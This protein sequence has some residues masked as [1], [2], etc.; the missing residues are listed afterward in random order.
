MKRVEITLR[1]GA[2]LAAIV[3][4][5]S[6]AQAQSTLPPPDVAQAQ[7]SPSTEATSADEIVVTGS[8]IAR[9]ALRDIPR[10]LGA[11]DFRLDDEALSFIAQTAG[12][13]A[14]RAL[15]LLEAAALVADLKRDLGQRP[16]EGGR[17]LGGVRRHLSQD[18][19]C[20]HNH[21]YSESVGSETKLA[22]A[23]ALEQ[24]FRRRHLT[25][26]HA[27]VALVRNRLQRHAQVAMI[28]IAQLSISGTGAV[29]SSTA[30][31]ARSIEILKTDFSG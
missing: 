20:R 17:F 7:A 22:P 2:A 19:P 16:P 21:K 31:A 26:A 1:A 13:D 15:N 12:G 29:K 4:G 27:Q 10:G 23:A 9:R 14:R 25:G 28:I 24:G 3:A 5:S 6:G 30:C 11:R 18:G 8:R